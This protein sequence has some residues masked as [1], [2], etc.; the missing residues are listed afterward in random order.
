MAKS[1]VQKLLE[2]GV[3]FTEMSRQQAETFVRA[4]VKSGEV[5][6]KDAEDTIQSLVE[7]SRET[8]D[9]VATLVQQE[10]SKQVTT[11]AEQY[12]DLENRIEALTGQLARLAGTNDAIE[13]SAP[14]RQADNDAAAKEQAPAKKKAAAKKTAAKKKTPA[15]R[16]APAKQASGDGA[17]GS[18][19]VR[20]VSTSRPD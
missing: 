6:R 4:L 2:A 11:I 3:Q 20:R 12:E 19:G 10:V 9:R 13:N 5:R 18:S 17:V 1:N 8:T 7:R 14:A 15:K 16:N